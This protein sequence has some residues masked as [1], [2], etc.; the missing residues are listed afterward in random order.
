MNAKACRSN[1]LSML[2]FFQT[3]IMNIAMHVSEVGNV[4]I[5]RFLKK[6]EKPFSFLETSGLRESTGMVKCGKRFVDKGCQTDEVIILP[7]EQPEA[8]ESLRPYSIFAEETGDQ[9]E[10]DGGDEHELG[11]N[12]KEEEFGNQMEE[13]G[14]QLEHNVTNANEHVSSNDTVIA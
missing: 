5:K 10:E 2:S 3:S 7:V 6:Q 9:M 12:I 13:L 11:V 8:E 4:N 14:N 1:C